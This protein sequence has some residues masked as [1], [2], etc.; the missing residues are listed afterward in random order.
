MRLQSQATLIASL[1]DQV[2]S[3][4]AALQQTNADL[5]I[6][7]QQSDKFKLVLVVSVKIVKLKNIYIIVYLI[8]FI[9]FWQNFHYF[10]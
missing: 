2:Q 9:F 8:S 3:L 6:S 1:Q 5:G 10:A 4:Q 7:N